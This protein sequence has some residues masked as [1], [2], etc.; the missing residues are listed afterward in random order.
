MLLSAT[1][2]NFAMRRFATWAVPNARLT[3]SG[4]EITGY[5]MY[6]SSFASAWAN[7]I[8]LVNRSGFEVTG[9]QMFIRA[10]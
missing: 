8:A 5:Q 6:S 10:A 7:P 4:F 9:Y 2:N 3:R 1:R